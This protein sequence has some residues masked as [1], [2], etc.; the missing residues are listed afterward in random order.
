MTKT[1]ATGGV[2]FDESVLLDADCLRQDAVV[3]SM[4]DEL[5]ADIEEERVSI[6]V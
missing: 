5:P 4:Q 3:T 2:V 1:N 6:A